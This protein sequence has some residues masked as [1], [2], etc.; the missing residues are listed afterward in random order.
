VV[1]AVASGNHGGVDKTNEDIHVL[2][3]I[4]CPRVSSATARGWKAYTVEG[5]LEDDVPSLAF[6]CP[7]CARR[8][9]A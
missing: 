4:D 3:C 9:S 5:R 1:A 8:E 7:E 6:Y 2:A